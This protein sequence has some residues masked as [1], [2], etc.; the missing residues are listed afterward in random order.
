MHSQFGS[1]SAYWLANKATD[2]FYHGTESLVA[3]FWESCWEELTKCMI[4]PQQRTALH[5]YLQY[6]HDF[7]LS[8]STLK[9]E[10]ETV[11]EMHF[12]ILNDAK[13]PFSMS[14]PDFKAVEECA[15]CGSCRA[16]RHLM[17]YEETVAHHLEQAMRTIE[18][19]A[20]HLLVHNKTFL[21]DFN[22]YLAEKLQ[23]NL[24]RLG[25]LYPEDF[26]EVLKLRTPKFWPLWLE[27][28][29]VYREQ[30]RCA[31]CGGDVSG[32]M[33]LK[34]KYVVGYLVP[35]SANGNNDPTNL[36]VLCLHCGREQSERLRQSN[37]RKRLFA[38]FSGGPHKT[39]K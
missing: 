21:R 36:Q 17:E 22:M 25:D 1:T 16:C 34:S 35:L 39:L 14:Y 23:D 12:R 28:A 27:R 29:L 33:N 13:I 4:A 6:L 38:G 5:V 30:G 11:F 32:I 7:T 8:F 9:F 26:T 19:A 3:Y 31:V 18:H 10:R 37:W 2:E 20:F 15:S 24:P